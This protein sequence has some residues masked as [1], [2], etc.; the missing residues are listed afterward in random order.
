MAEFAKSI[1]SD[2]PITVLPNC[3]NEL[4]WQFP[5]PKREGIRIGYA[6]SP[7]H[8]PDLLKVLPIIKNLQAKYPEKDIRFFLMGFGPYD[9]KTSFKQ[10]RYVATPEVEV[11]C[12][13]VDSYLKQIN[14]E[15]VPFVPYDQYFSTLTNLALDFGLCPLTNTPFNQHRSAI[16]ALEYLKSGALALASNIEGYNDDFTSVLVNDD[17]WQDKLEFCINNPA[18]VE[19]T[20]KLH[21]QWAREN[22]NI[23]DQVELLKKV[24]TK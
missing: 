8:L 23:D 22:R 6:G 11:I 1:R 13:E 16:K 14:W 21:L 3:Y 18:D 7:T 24:Y 15:W 20:K 5:R 17:Q 19:A 9:Y 2:V 12:K 4:D 10:I